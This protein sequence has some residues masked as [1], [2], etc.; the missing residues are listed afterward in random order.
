MLNRLFSKNKLKP[1]LIYSQKGN[2][3]RIHF[4]GDILVCE[5]RDLVSKEVYFCSMN[6]KTN[7]IFLRNFQ[8]EEKWWVSVDSIYKETLFLNYFKTPE[9]PEHLGITAVD[10]KTGT[11]KWMNTD[12]IFWFATQNDVYGVKELFERKLYFRLDINSGGICEE[13]DD[14]EIEIH[15]SSL[16]KFQESQRYKSFINAEIYNATDDSADADIKEY[17]SGRFKNIHVFGDIEFAKYKEFLIY[18]YHKDE[19]VNLKD[20]NEKTLSNILEIYDMNGHSL[21]FTDVL[22]KK[23]SNYVPD[24]FFVNDGYLFFVKEKRELTVINLNNS[25]K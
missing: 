18:N 9:L 1:S 23:A 10:L 8:I 25:S 19:G 20:L 22:N 13:Y 17:I 3:W 2:I 4:Y 16:Q 6:Y 12:L 14:E 5:T 15:L 11:V 7:Q 24:S 21:T